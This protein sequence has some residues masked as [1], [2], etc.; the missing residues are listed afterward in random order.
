MPLKK[1]LPKSLSLPKP[2]NIVEKLKNWKSEP[3]P[4]VFARIKESAVAVKQ[5]LSSG[6]SKPPP[7]VPSP[8]VPVPHKIEHWHIILGIAVLVLLIFLLRR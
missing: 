7:G 4:N 5:G 6:I 3:K 2:S 1:P 8:A